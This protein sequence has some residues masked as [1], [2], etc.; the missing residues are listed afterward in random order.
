MI[1]LTNFSKSFACI[2]QAALS[3]GLT[4]NAQTQV[5]T[6]PAK[7]WESVGQVTVPLSKQQVLVTKPLAN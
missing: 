2:T 4:A 6:M 1:L 3:W 7:G 5:F